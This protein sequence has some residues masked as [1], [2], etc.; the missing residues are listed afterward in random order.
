VTARY[1]VADVFDGLASLEDGSVDLVVTSPPFLALRSYLP[2]DHP[3]K[4][5]EI[6]SEPTPAEFIDTMLAVCAE[7]RRVLAPHGSMCLEIGDTYSG[8]GGGG[9][10]YLENGWREGQ[11]QFAG[12]AASMRESNAAHWRQKNQNKDGWPLAKSK[13]LIP[14]LL[15]VALAYGFN[16]LTGQESPAGRWRVRNVVTWARPN[17]PVG[18][19][20]DK[21][22]PATSDVIVACTS[23]RRYWDD[24]A[25]RRPTERF[26]KGG[27]RKGS[28]N[29]T[30]ERRAA[31]G[32]SFQTGGSNPSGAPLLD[33]WE[34]PPTGYAGSH[35]AVFPPA[36]VVPL[37][38]AMC[39]EFVCPNCGPIRRLEY[40]DDATSLRAMQGADNE[41]LGVEGDSGQTSLLLQTV[42]SNSDA[43][44][45]AGRDSSQELPPQEQ[46]IR[47]R[48]G[49]HA[50]AP[51]GE[52]VR[53]AVRAS[54]SDGRTPWSDADG[55]RSGSPQER[56][57]GRQPDRE[58]GSDAP[59]G[60][61]QDSDST[62][63]TKALSS[64]R[65]DSV[66]GES[67]PSCGAA[68][69]KGVV[70]DPFA[71][72][73]TTLAVSHGHGHDTIGI[74]LDHRNVTLARERVGPM[75]FEEVDVELQQ[76]PA[77]DPILE[78]RGEGKP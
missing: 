54:S 45:E 67:C 66:G 44:R 29:G 24:L 39:P 62:V 4:S 59:T 48:G 71:G 10:D 25:T 64:L 15:E 1:I 7:L 49:S 41:S 63:E 42:F 20:G 11:Q 74:D 51:N 77:R 46:A 12:S 13:T 3:D 40:N 69:R 72:S 60:P 47:L 6:G 21:W 22:R 58:F 17:P 50:G 32:E 5:K 31:D 19:L 36:L 35:Y 38:K 68:L 30:D 27:L 8:S 9:G 43:R 78:V 33:Y 18:A 61:R 52:Q 23:D 2:A 70:L 28:I 26:D 55:R 14:Q 76:D 53:D 57:T 37:V 73:G 16:P 65:R 75:F 56:D 34:I